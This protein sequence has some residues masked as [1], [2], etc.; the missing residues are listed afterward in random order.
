[1]TRVEQLE[2]AVGSLPVDEYRQFRDWFIEREWSEWDKQIASDSDSGK[3]DFLL[4]EAANEKMQG[5]LHPL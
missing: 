5:R 2:E 4:E 1:M 3:L